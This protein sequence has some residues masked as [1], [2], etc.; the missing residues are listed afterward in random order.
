MSDEL[1][2]GEL[3]YAAILRAWQEA[4]Q[5]ARELFAGLHWRELKEAADRHRQLHS[6]LRVRESA[7][8]QRLPRGRR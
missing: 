5:N 7:A 6:W 4:D 2:H 3:V 1:H 8:K